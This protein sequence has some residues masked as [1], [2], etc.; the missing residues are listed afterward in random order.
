MN[1]N[2]PHTVDTLNQLLHADTPVFSIFMNT[3]NPFACEIFAKRD[4]ILLPLIVNM[5]YLQK[6]RLYTHFKPFKPP[7]LCPLPVAVG[8]TQ[9]ILCGY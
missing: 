8:T 6:I 5:V 4:Y 3:G 7:M 2:T 1:P 9:H